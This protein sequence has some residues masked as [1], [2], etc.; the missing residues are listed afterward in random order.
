[1]MNIISVRQ[2][3]LY[4]RTWILNEAINDA[5]N[6]DLMFV[7]LLIMPV[8]FL[9]IIF[10]IIANFIFMIIENF[11]LKLRFKLSSQIFSI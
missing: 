5:H 10:M 1:M 9:I 2:F 8:S 6:S 3:A 7:C 4:N 11:T